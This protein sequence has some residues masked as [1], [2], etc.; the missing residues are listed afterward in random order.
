MKYMYIEYNNVDRLAD[1]VFYH[2]FMPH[3]TARVIWRWT[4]GLKSHLKDVRSPG[5]PHNPGPGLQCRAQL[6]KINDIVS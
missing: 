5:Q 3:S 2:Y 4:L 6:S 1:F